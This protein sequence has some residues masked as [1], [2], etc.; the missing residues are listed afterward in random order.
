MKT[1]LSHASYLLKQ[2]N[3]WNKFWTL[4]SNKIVISMKTSLSH[5]S[6]LLKQTNSWNKFLNT[7]LKQDCHFNEDISISCF[8]FVKTNKIHEISFWTLHSNKIVIS[9]K[10]ISLTSHLFQISFLQNYIKAMW[11]HF[12]SYALL[13]VFSFA[14]LYKE[15]RRHYNLSILEIFT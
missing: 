11:P 1:S 5:A 14:N 2:T 4:H 13:Q 3:L 7:S 8:T 15:S 9:M 12:V 6:H 10:T